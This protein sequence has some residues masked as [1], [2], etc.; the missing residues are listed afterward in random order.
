MEL[1][2]GTLAG[3]G[4]YLRSAGFAADARRQSALAR[5][6]ANVR[7]RIGSGLIRDYSTMRLPVSNRNQIRRSAWSI[8]VSIRLA[9]A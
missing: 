4:G 5:S 8:Q 3:V 6:D 2:K 1:E 9:V 7:Q